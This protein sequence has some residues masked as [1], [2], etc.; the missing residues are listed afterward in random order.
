M[1]NSDIFARYMRELF[2]IIVI[3]E[4]QDK[5]I[6]IDANGK[7]KM[8]WTKFN[9]K[10]AITGSDSIAPAHMSSRFDIRTLPFRCNNGL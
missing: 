5:K 7:I 10:S 3:I 2:T 1:Y 6:T 4:C 9:G 8:D